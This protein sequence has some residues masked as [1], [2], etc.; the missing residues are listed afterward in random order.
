MWEVG[1]VTRPM[2]VLMMIAM[3]VV[4]GCPVQDPQAARLEVKDNGD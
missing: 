1:D 2:L 3:L 4:G